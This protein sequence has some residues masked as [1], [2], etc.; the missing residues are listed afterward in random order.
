M[1][2]GMNFPSLHAW[3]S[4]FQGGLGV[5]LSCTTSSSSVAIPGITEGIDQIGILNIGDNLAFVVLGATGLSATTA[6]L[7]IP[8]LAPIFVP[9]FLYRGAPAIATHIAGITATSTATLVI[10]TGQATRN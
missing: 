7:V 4:L 8:V 9:P 3:A 2:S 10:T 1:P 5:R 6:G